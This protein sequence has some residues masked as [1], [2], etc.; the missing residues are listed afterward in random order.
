MLKHLDLHA[1][2]V[3][4]FQRLVDK[5]RVTC[6]RFVPGSPNHFLASFASG[7]VYVF[8]HELACPPSAPVYQ[9]FKQGDGFTI[10]TCKA[11]STR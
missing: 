10:Y 1:F 7:N 3:N 2:D 9:T 6:I 11:K 8:N 4:I 5:T